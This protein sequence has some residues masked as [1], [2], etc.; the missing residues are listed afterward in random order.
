VIDWSTVFDESY[1]EVGATDADIAELI[2]AARA[3]LA[4]AEIREILEAQARLPGKRFP[5]DDPKTWQLPQRQL[6]ASYLTFLRWSNGGQ[7]RKGERWFDPFFSTCEVRGYMLGYDLPGRIP[8]ALAFAFNGGGVFYLFDMRADP[9]DGE[10]PVIA[11]HAGAP[12]YASS[13]PVAPSFPEVCRGTLDPFD[14]R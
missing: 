13:W 1:P 8:L 12:W 5:E 3:P 2:S 9:V 14:L 6:P 11:A 4:E 10:Y 7:F